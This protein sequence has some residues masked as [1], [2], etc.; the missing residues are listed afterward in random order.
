MDHCSQ[1]VMDRWSPH[2]D[3]G[4]VSDFQCDVDDAEH[5]IK[6][7]V[8]PI[9]PKSPDDPLWVLAHS[10]GG[11][12][13]GYVVTRNPGMFDKVIFSAPMFDVVGLPGSPPACF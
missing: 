5:F 7:I 6:K 12:V 3:R 8:L 10:M 1:G 2:S 4:L 13:N 9:F 11:L